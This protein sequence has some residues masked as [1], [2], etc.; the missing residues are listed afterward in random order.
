MST[1][2]LSDYYGHDAALL[3][4]E[5]R[6]YTALGERFHD[7]YGA[8]PVH[9]YR[10]PGRI[11]LIG[12]HTDYNGGFVMPVALDRDVLFAVRPRED[13]VV[14][15]ANVEETFAPFSFSLAT[16]IPH[17]PRGDWRNY[18]QGAA[19]ELCR[20]F[21][22]RYELKGAEILVDGA[23]PLGVP[24]GA[25]LSS[26]TALT[27]DAALTLVARNEIE[28]ERAELA[29]LCSEAE[30]YVGTRGGMMD[31]F[32]ALLCQRDHALFLDCRPSLDGAYQWEQVPVPEEAQLVLLN[33]GVYHENAR[34]A[35]NQRV[36]ECKIGVHL[37]QQQYPQIVQLRDVTPV[38]LELAEDDFWEMIEATLPA[39]ATLAELVAAGALRSWIEEVMADHGLAEDTTFQILSRCRHVITEN[40]RVLAGMTALRAGQLDTFG[41]LMDAAHASMSGDYDASCLEVDT[42][43][44]LA[45]QEPAVLGARITGA[46]W[47]GGV[48]V[49][50]HRTEGTAWT[51]RVATAYRASTGLDAQ[52]LF[53]RPGRGAGEVAL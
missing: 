8:G 3:E 51:E 16:D 36:A 53:C 11:N 27:V 31:Q 6:R 22:D 26:S 23:A 5:R 43:V 44:S 17:A 46:G 28:V 24:R 20:R 18:F 33:S 9:Y 34:G 2:E 52:I 29:H 13:A 50:A 25:G 47:G 12:E 45:G 30:W 49:L 41:L 48:V 19:Q 21:G 7:R 14:S 40:E 1:G 38:A 4:T 37:L 32:S 35:F 42:L 15:V 39:R 10:T